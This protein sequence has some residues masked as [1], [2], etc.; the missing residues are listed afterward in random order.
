[1]PAAEAIGA[2]M[3]RWTGV[4]Q[5]M[6]AAH[7]GLETIAVPQGPRQVDVQF[8]MG[9]DARDPVIRALHAA[10]V[11]DGVHIRNDL[12]AAWL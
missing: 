11:E 9:R 2:G 7:Q 12:K 1:M 4:Q 8:I 3:G 10:L 6:I 5:A